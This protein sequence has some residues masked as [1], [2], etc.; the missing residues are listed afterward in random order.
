MLE[1]SAKAKGIELKGIEKY[2]DAFRNGAL[3]H[4]GGGIGLERVIMLFL[5]LPNI[6]KTA[7]FPRDPKRLLP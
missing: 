7:L 5:G 1:E 6:R 3:P 2:I 4:A